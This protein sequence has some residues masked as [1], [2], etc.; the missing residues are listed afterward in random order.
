MTTFKRIRSTNMGILASCFSGE[1][2]PGFKT[3]NTKVYAN[4]YFFRH[5]NFRAG[6]RYL[7]DNL[8]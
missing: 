2:I 5:L 7:H 6:E 1:T 4:L 3:T 8:V